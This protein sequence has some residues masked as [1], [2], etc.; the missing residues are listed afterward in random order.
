MRKLYTH[1]EY[2]V[3]Y[4]ADAPVILSR[5][6]DNT[7]ERQ[8]DVTPVKDLL[9]SPALSPGC[10]TVYSN[11][12]KLTLSEMQPKHLMNVRR[13][14]VIPEFVGKKRKRMLDAVNSWRIPMNSVM[15]VTLSYPRD[16]SKNW[17][18]WKNDL[19]I[20]K[21]HLLRKYP[22]SQGFWKLELQKRGAPHYHM[23]LDTGEETSLTDFRNWNDNLWAN[24]AHY[25]DCHAGVYACTVKKMRTPREAL[26]Y[27][28][29]YQTKE[30]Y[31]P[32]DADGVR[33]TA[34][35]L[36]DSIGR[37]WGKIGKPDCSPSE[38][39][40]VRREWALNRKSVLAALL[41]EAGQEKY[42]DYLDRQGAHNSI[43]LYG[44][45]DT[46]LADEYKNAPKPPSFAFKIHPILQRERAYSVYSAPKHYVRC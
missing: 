22:K 6:R 28:A 43:T 2:S 9:P 35:Q 21:E 25:M 17:K 10:I 34:E 41:R 12:V 15:F 27:A 11:M 5:W 1:K 29:K 3:Q 42:A 46:P 8:Y 13:G 7:G 44:L 31:A 33:L 36:G 32:V 19:K 39:I 23:V 26:N 37:L 24:I 16:Y 14:D 20:W 40:M 45:G 38:K 30:T 4:D 18:D